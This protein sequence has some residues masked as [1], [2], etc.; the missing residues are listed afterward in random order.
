MPDA[1]SSVRALAA[2]LY[3]RLSAAEGNLAF[4]PYSVAVALAM[5]GNGARGETSGEMLRVLHVEGLTRFNGGLNAL[6][7]R[8]EGIAGRTRRLDGSHAELRLDTASSLWGQRGTRWQKPFLVTLAREYGAGMRLV[9]YRNRTEDARGLINAWTAQQT[10]Q[11]IK[12]ILQ[13]GV[14]DTL[15]RLVLVN[16]IY[17]KAPWEEPFEKRNTAV[18]PFLLGGGARVG[19]HMMTATLKTGSYG[20]GPGWRAV[21]LPY[22]GRE[23]AM[24]VVLPD[25]GR[26]AS[27][28]AALTGDRLGA[29]LAAPRRRAVEL[30]LPLWTFRT[31]ASLDDPLK[32]MGMA[33]AFDPEH[34]D[35]TGMTTEEQL[36][37]SAVEHEAFVAVDEAGTEAAAATAAVLG[38]TSA[39]ISVP[40]V[41][42]RPFLFVIHDV[43]QNTPLFLGRVQ[44]PR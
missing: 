6:S 30:S 43:A 12:E 35:F 21:R 39:E 23:L 41:V 1:A 20:E 7:R 25:E 16:A 4:S 27:V 36:F 19:V 17:L 44:D 38:T 14:L 18:K 11:R 22:A 3:R 34:A 15:T 5:A 13:P 29:V 26:M 37:I 32:A 9:D 28:E 40:V 8:V 42:D 33:T 10:H 24:T 2:D 31:R